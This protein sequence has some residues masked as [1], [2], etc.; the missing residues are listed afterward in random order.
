MKNN[1]KLPA[2]FRDPSGFLFFD[3]GV[4]YRQINLVYQDNY[5][6]LMESGLI[7]HLVKKGK[8]VPHTDAKLTPSAPKNAYKVIQPEQLGFISYPYEWSFSQLKDAALLTLNIQKRALK[9]GMSL[10]DSSAYN[11]QFQLKNAKPI[12][13]DT[14]SFE[15]YEEGSPWVA[16]RQYYQHL[17]APLA[18][19]AHTDVRLSQ[20]MRVYID[21]IPLDLVSRLLPRKT[22]LNFGLLSHIHMHASV[23]KRYADSGEEVGKVSQKRKM[24][25][26]NLLALIDSLDRTTKKLGLKATGTEWGEYYEDTNYSQKAHDH[27]KEIVAKYIDQAKPKSVWDL[28]ANTGLFSRIAS[29]KG[30]PTIAFD[31]DTDAVERNYLDIK[32]NKEK[33]L[34]PLA[35]DLT[36]PSPDIGWHNKERRTLLERTTPDLIIALALVH[37]L[38][39]SNNVPLEMIAEYFSE[40]SPWLILEFVPKSDSQVKRLLSTR[41]DIFPDYSFEGLEEAF[42]KYYDIKASDDIEDSERRM[43]LMKRK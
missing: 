20:L 33:N 24:S 1:Q 36:N 42:G 16:Y 11:I 10:K 13:I 6:K 28:G 5:E 7:D 17:L 18:L 35:L 9:R 15:I 27:K 4:L 43:Y 30:I 8:L 31:I 2:S 34:L 21:G 38:G 39:I 22:K 29:E 37:H 26:T 23:Q 32:A 14:L 25:K 41:D 3:K 19:M 12:L 40:L